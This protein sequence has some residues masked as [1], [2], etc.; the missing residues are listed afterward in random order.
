MRR[1]R[2]G[3]TRPDSNSHLF[4]PPLNAK[5]NRTKR[6]PVLFPPLRVHCI[7]H[8][9]QARPMARPM[10]RW[11]KVLYAFPV[12]YLG[13]SQ[14]VKPATST[15]LGSARLGGERREEACLQAK[16]WAIGNQE[17]ECVLRT[18]RQPGMTFLVIARWVLMGCC[19]DQSESDAVRHGTRSAA[20]RSYLPHLIMLTAG[21]ALPCCT[22]GVVWR[23]VAGRAPVELHTSP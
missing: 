1:S 11:K 17:C 23:S 18:G 15:M 22:R 19:L 9:R 8:L 5:L 12:E 16:Q 6:R 2:P 4:P 7:F 10:Q 3:P 20:Y 14:A 21:R 13:L